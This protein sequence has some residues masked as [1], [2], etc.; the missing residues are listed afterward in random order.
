MSRVEV[1]APRKS[2]NGGGHI[3]CEQGGAP[4]GDDERRGMIPEQRAEAVVFLWAVGAPFS[5]L[6]FALFASSFCLL[7]FLSLLSWR[8]AVLTARFCARL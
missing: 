6:F 3:G 4:G 8:V 7:S 2:V 5:R 1:R